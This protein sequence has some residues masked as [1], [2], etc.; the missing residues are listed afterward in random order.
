[1][2]DFIEE[3]IRNSPRWVMRDVDHEKVESLS[4]RTG[5]S[6]LISRLLILRGV[7]AEED[8]RSFLDDDL[9]SLENP[10]LFSQ[11][12]PAVGRVRKAVSEGE[13]I[14]IFGDRDVDGVLSTAMLHNML[15]RFDADVICKVPEGEYGYGIEEKD[16]NSAKEQGSGLI[17][18]VDTGISS[19]EEIAYASS[20]GLDAIIIDH[21]VQPAQIPKA[22]AVLNPKMEQETY[23]FKY[24]SAGGVVLK[25]IHAFILTYTKNFNR[26]FFLLLPKG[27]R[28]AGVRIRNGIVEEKL[29]IEESIHYPIDKTALVVSDSTKPLPPFFLSW[30]KESKIDQLSL[31]STHTYEGIEEFARM[32][33]KLFFHRQKKSN[34]FVR[35]FI[36]LSAVSTISDIMPLVGEN[37]VIVKE[38]LKQLSRTVNT[39]LA[40]L[41][42]YCDIPDRDPTAR[43]VAWNLSPL[44]NSAGRMG[45]ANIAVR[46]FITDDTAEANELSKVLVEMNTRRREKGD[47]N[48]NIIMPIVED[49]YYKDPVIILDTDKAEHGVTG[50]IAGKIA[51]KFGR[52]AIVI[53]NDGKIGVGSG[54]G[55]KGFDLV[56]LI[57]R[58][59]D[60]LV[61][62]G[63]HESAV[64]FSIDIVKIDSFRKR[65]HEIARS[66]YDFFNSQE[67]LE[68]DAP[69]DPDLI[70][71][72]LLDE[73]AVLEPTGCGNPA[74]QFVIRK[75][76]AI[77]PAH[78]GKDKTHVKL[79]IPA[80]GGIIPVIGWGM[81][82]KAFRILEEASLI[83]IV[84]SLEDNYFR[85]ERSLQLILH[86]IK[87]SEG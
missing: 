12:M 1:M 27:D 15:K 53:V 23:P 14:F 84:F 68:I 42:G 31:I 30:L 48:F 36:D 46:L 11:M 38:G 44:I 75:V 3:M 66:E 69:I 74:P 21:H 65:I 19:F 29:T 86:D 10:Y 64:G 34:E 35:N 50:I 58:C 67:I 79:H 81:A 13:K 56:S 85:G 49:K 7:E 24:L 28:I 55:G 18:T 61:K 16:V 52:P 22:F 83:D 60:L 32:F 51:R 25:F 37:R 8:L 4:R 26:P 70:N 47:K 63:G 39:G 2:P 45:D 57:S 6:E 72:D 20:L 43:D 9:D 33:K 41:L 77:N 5:Y 82:D 87:P 76:S 59:S 40:V 17:I 71:S 73:L 78:I 54:R 62:Y 80:G